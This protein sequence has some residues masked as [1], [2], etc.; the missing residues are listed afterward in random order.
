MLHSTTKRSNN[1][2]QNSIDEIDTK[3]FFVTY[4]LTVSYSS[5]SNIQS[6]LNWKRKK[7]LL[8]HTNGSH[9]CMRKKKCGIAIFF[10]WYFV[11]LTL[12]LPAFPMFMT[13]WW[14]IENGM[15]EERNEKKKFKCQMKFHFILQ[16]K[17][18][19]VEKLG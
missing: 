12:H 4:W 18:K 14:N 3:S 9:V 7:N 16:K 15:I 2:R 1:Y 6:V 19:K 17:K 5:Y 8:L 13:Q 11:S 10:L